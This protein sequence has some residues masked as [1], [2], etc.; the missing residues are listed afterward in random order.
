ML[1]IWAFR[2]SIVLLQLKYIVF[3][4]EKKLSRYGFNVDSLDLS[5]GSAAVKIP[6]GVLPF[7]KIL[8][9]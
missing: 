5:Y 3:C 6:V 1:I 2:R 7:V 8:K 9:G 4:Y